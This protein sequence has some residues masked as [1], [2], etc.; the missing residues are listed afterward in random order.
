VTVVRGLRKI[1]R[2]IWSL[3]ELFALLFRGEKSGKDETEELIGT[4]E[5]LQS[6]DAETS[7]A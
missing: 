5:N 6:E 3:L 1:Q 4:V 7:S 2:S